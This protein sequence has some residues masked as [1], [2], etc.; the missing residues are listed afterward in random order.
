[1]RSGLLSALAV[2]GYEIFLEGNNIKY[3][4]QKTGNPPESVRQLID[5][6]RRCKA[7]VV[8]ILRMD[9]IITPPEKTH[10]GANTTVIWRNPYP[11]G[12]SEAR[13]AWL[14][15]KLCF[16]VFLLWM[17]NKTGRSTT[18]RKMFCQARQS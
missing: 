9:N 15:L 16:T 7:E 14:L 17:M 6:L 10:P 11:Q 3:R 18:W 12:T 4:Y 2:F 5:E 1:M 8:N 13:Q